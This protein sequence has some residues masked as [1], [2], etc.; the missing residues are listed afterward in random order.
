MILASIFAFSVIIL[1]FAKNFKVHMMG[2]WRKKLVEKKIINKFYNGKKIYNGKKKNFIME[3]K[4]LFFGKLAQGVLVWKISTILFD[5]MFL[6]R[7]DPSLKR[8]KWLE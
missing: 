8:Y 3:K 1:P 6:Y 2:I 5:R 4:I 7:L